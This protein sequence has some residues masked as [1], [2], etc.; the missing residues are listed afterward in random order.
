MRNWYRFKCTVAALALT[1][2]CAGSA[3]ADDPGFPAPTGDPAFVPAG[4][5][6]ERL[7][8][9]GYM[10]TEGVAAGHNGMIDFSDITFTKF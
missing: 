10:L 3:C 6:L 2:A 4:A 5:K 8:D 1:V 9:G 7:F